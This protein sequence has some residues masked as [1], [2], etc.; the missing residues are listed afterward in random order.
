[1]N[2]MPHLR[3]W[4][5]LWGL[6]VVSILGLTV[7]ACG[8]TPSTKSAPPTQTTTTS[9]NVHGTSQGVTAHSITLGVAEPETGTGAADW[10]SVQGEQ[11]YFDYANAHGGVKGRKIQLIAL[12]DQYDPQ[13]NIQDVRQLIDEDHVFALAGG[14]GTPNT[15][16]SIPLIVQSKIPDIGPNAPS[17]TLGTMATP[18]V[19]VISPN[20]TQQFKA[21]T[22]Y[23]ESHY[24]PSSYSLVGVTGSVDQSA[25]AGMKA[26]V[27]SGV[28]INNIPETP[29]TA[30][31][32]P[33]AEQLQ[34]YN[35]PWVFF[36]L[37]DP[38]TGNLLEAMK[39]IGYTPR[40]ASWSGMTEKSAF[41][42]PYGAFAQGLIAIEAELPVD[43]NALARKNGQLET[44][45]LHHS[46]N[47]FQEM[48]WA[49]GAVTVAALRGAKALTWSCL[50]ASLNSLHDVNVGFYPP[51]SFSPESRQGTT[52]VALAKIE[53]SGLVQVSG[54]VGA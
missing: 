15:L 18:N 43:A 21:L 6:G 51:I 27:P 2:D 11:A 44:Q 13:T 33:L 42:D 48:G 16:A 38:D 23:V 34:H 19:F 53:G 49:Q 7:A 52:D 36:I 37:T 35:A 47:T 30:N 54:F 24:H 1:M 50:T 10:G 25:L 26:A 39:R 28:V 5:R 20:Y 12:N 14:N 31:M 4:P 29:G 9:C 8:A 41:I 45:Y 46:P 32:A 22:K 3:G 40:M 17:N